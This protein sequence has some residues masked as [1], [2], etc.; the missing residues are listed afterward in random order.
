MDT[1]RIPCSRRRPGNCRRP[2]PIHA[3]GVA[4]TGGDLIS[5][6]SRWRRDPAYGASAVV[7]NGFANAGALAGPALVGLLGAKGGAI[8]SIGGAVSVLMALG[9][10]ASGLFLLAAGLATTTLPAAENVSL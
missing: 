2:A 8:G 1:D 5:R 10:G 7:G 9:L 4:L 3:L 6:G